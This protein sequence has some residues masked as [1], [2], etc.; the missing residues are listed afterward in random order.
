[1]LQLSKF[2]M[3]HNG[4]NL[5]HLPLLWAIGGCG[6]IG[7][8]P[9]CKGSPTGISPIA[10]TGSSLANKELSLTF[11]RSPSN[12]TAEFSTYLQSRGIGATFFIEGQRVSTTD[13][14]VALRNEGHLI[15][16]GT[17]SH[18]DLTQ[19][20]DLLTEIRQVDDLITP[21]VVGD[22]FVF[23]AP[24]G[25]FEKKTAEYLNVQ[26][27]QKYVGP[28]GW[29]IGD[30]TSAVSID[31]TCSQDGLSPS[32][33]A[34]RYLEKITEEKRGIIRF[35]EDAFDLPQ[36]LR[37]LIPNLEAALYKFVRIDQ[38]PNIKKEILKRGGQPG[39]VADAGGCNDYRNP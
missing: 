38:I 29:D 5:L 3:L 24:E 30:E 26:G 22:I 32:A 16:N 12:R 34:Q 14:L 4:I 31:A 6:F 23:T 39:V 19:T 20:P 35:T 7:R 17:V 8:D 27:L 18:A 2:W 13:T 1:M 9:S 15:G 28:I 10:L 33:C 21:Y 36:L 25:R 11:E 37:E